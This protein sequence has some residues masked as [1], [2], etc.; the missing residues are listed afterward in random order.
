MSWRAMEARGRMLGAAAAVRRREAI[1]RAVGEEAPGVVVTV[2][3]DDV[4]L[5][6]RGLMRSWMADLALRMAAGGGR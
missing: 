5:E 2:Q 1:A 3:G 4:V 6:G